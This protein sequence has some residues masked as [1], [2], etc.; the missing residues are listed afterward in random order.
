MP[1]N[2][3]FLSVMQFRSVASRPH[4]L[5][6]SVCLPLSY[7]P[8]TCAS[9][10]TLLPSAAPHSP[11]RQKLNLRMKSLSLDSP[12]STE[13]HGQM[14]RRYPGGTVGMGHPGGP[15]GGGGGFSSHN[16]HGGSGGQLEH[17][18]PPSNNS[19]LHCKW[20]DDD[21][22]DG[23]ADD[24]KEIK[25]LLFPLSPALIFQQLPRV[26]RSNSEGCCTPIGDSARDPWICLMTSTRVPRPRARL[27]V[28]RP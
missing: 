12:E 28:R 24:R 23:D 22:D 11:R 16:Y 19:R 1:L 8:I 10:L 5:L 17:S 25:T 20:S 2:G 13:L 7:S 15:G 6:L 26:R 18:T 9:T 21:D 4:V 27:H 14:R 3:Q